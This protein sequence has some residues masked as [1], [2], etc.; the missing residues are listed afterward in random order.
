MNTN[1]LE[2]ISNQLTPQMIQK[3][4][5]RLGET[6]AQTQK[7]VDE[8]IPTLL[9][10][11]MHFSSLT[12]GPTQLL[13]LLN[14]GNYGSLLNNLSGLCD[15]GD[16]TQRVMTVG[17]EILQVM[18]ADKLDAM[19]E[20]IAAASGVTNASASSLLSLTAPVVLGVL[21]RVR[22]AQGL[23][24][25]RLITLLMSQKEVIAKLTP[26]GLAEMFGVSDLT[27]LGA[28][29][30]SAMTEATP[31]PV[32]RMT[33]YPV[34]NESTLKKWRWPVLGVAAVGLLYF[35]MGRDTGVTKSLMVNW[36]SMTTSAVAPVTLPS[37]VILSLKEGSFN[38]NVAKFLADPA[39]MTV[40]KT[41]V[42]DRLHFDSGT[43]RFT[44]ESVQTVE[45]LSAIL[46]AY[47]AV[48]VRLDGH[49][50]DTGNAKENKKLSLDQA[51]VVREALIRGGVS[52]TRMTTAGY[53]QEYPLASNE[54]EEG[55]AKNQRLELVVVKK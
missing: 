47:P 10:G 24:A 9:A 19:S 18:S 6:P 55:R 38:Y 22:A 37:G 4:S 33:T 15:E 53:G 17:R 14:Q 27:N 50:N 16:T 11:L 36:K 23:N 49:T 41:F 54:T 39:L 8:A 3:V 46:K 30:A 28:R 40:P 51:I 25:A 2:N 26:V 35:L 34:R 44:P 48:D 20:R 7:A 31:A 12:N 32:R 45:E 29:P 5:S 52:A 42:F 21:E 1:L 43:T 13:T